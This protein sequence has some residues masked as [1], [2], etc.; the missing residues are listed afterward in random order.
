MADR[1]PE[2]DTFTSER[3][4]DASQTRLFAAWSNPELRKAWEP[5]PPGYT[6]I[7]AS[8]DFRVGGIESGALVKDGLTV[9]AFD[10]RYL[11]IAVPYRIVFSVKI[12]ENCH[13]VACSQNSI[14]FIAENAG[15]RVI[16][17]EQVVWP[18]GR[19]RR[20]E[21]HLNGQHLLERL[22]EGAFRTA[23]V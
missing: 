22:S 20:P 2:H 13:T 1:S 18:H 14:A 4:F 8:F 12:T 5:A 21:H 9:A 7:R 16:C 17:T 23:P 6:I 15:T 10:R 3:W 11:D 19:S